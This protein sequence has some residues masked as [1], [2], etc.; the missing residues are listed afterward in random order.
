M[1]NPVMMI[2]LTW[3]GIVQDRQPVT[4]KIN[5]S[6]T[7]RKPIMLGQVVF[8]SRFWQS[9]AFHLSAH[10]DT[11]LPMLSFWLHATCTMIWNSSA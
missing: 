10:G 4:I 9:T 3:N 8:L 6:D 5:Q 1:I 11:L 7:R 2:F